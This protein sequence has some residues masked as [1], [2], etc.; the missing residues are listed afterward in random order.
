MDAAAA[1]LISGRKNYVCCRFHVFRMLNRMELCNFI[2]QYVHY[3]ST[4]KIGKICVRLSAEFSSLE[5]SV[6][7]GII[8][9]A[10]AADFAKSC[11]Y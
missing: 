8:S 11:L 7:S 9:L 5:N 3:P 1:R 2:A 6:S 4:D 10:Q